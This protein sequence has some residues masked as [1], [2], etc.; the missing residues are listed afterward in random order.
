MFRVMKDV[1][2]SS[3]EGENKTLT[4]DKDFTDTQT[5]H[6]DAA[7]EVRS[8]EG[9]SE[10]KQNH[11][12]AADVT[13]TEQKKDKTD[14]RGPYKEVVTMLANAEK[15][16]PL[17]GDGDD[18]EEGTSKSSSRRTGTMIVKDKWPQDVTYAV[19]K[20]LLELCPQEDEH[21]VRTAIS[22]FVKPQRL[23][24]NEGLQ[25][26]VA[27]REA[28]EWWDDGPPP[29]S[30]GLQGDVQMHV[31]RPDS[32]M[33]GNRLQHNRQTQWT[34]HRDD[35]Q[36][37]SNIHS[38]MDQKPWVGMF[39]HVTSSNE[40]GH[41]IVTYKT[42][43]M[44]DTQLIK[45]KLPD[46]NAGGSLWIKA[47]LKACSGMVPTMGDFRLV[48]CA[49]TSWGALT[50]LEGAVASFGVPDDTPLERWVHA[51]WPRIRD[52]FPINME[53][54]ELNNIPPRKDERGSVYLARVRELW[55]PKI[56][57]DPVYDRPSWVMFKSAVLTPQ[58]DQV[59]KQLE[60]VVG[61][62]RLD[63][64]LWSDHVVH[65]IDKQVKDKQAEQQE[66]KSLEAQLAKSKLKDLR[67]KV[68]QPKEKSAV[69]MPQLVDMPHGG[70]Q[71][72][73]SGLNK[74]SSKSP[75]ERYP[76]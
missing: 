17:F 61:L 70:P 44:Q 18:P 60:C 59:R 63:Y 4:S 74:L 45:Q 54:V 13:E 51:L 52:R 41:N 72:E 23:D 47:F 37:R 26:E 22:K 75:G 35:R 30:G 42:F 40:A 57:V 46:L 3:K 50:E 73:V 65:F 29:P 28:S 33:Q 2:T 16:M 7:D 62:D 68:N 66:M 11:Q 19:V 5:T 21:G 64:D 31:M 67:D 43:S 10:T 20:G 49:C 53:S 25:D 32:T 39:P 55:G 76:V 36:V 71:Q 1:L 48:Y 14:N 12:V 8:H 27:G 15:Q 34:Q 6:C 58:T 56:G 38:C 69:Q 24:R 9:A